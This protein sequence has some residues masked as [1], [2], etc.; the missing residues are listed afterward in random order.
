MDTGLIS[1]PVQHSNLGTNVNLFLE[2]NQT[3]ETL[4]F[5]PIASSI[6]N[7]GVFQDDI[8]LFGLTYLQKI[9]RRDHWR[10]TS[11]RAWNLG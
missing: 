4:K 9:K 3:E 11:H 7:R 6:P 5:D 2:L 8:E 10:S 1:W